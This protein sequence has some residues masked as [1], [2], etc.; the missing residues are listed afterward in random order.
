MSF[1]PPL[2]PKKKLS[3]SLDEIIAYERRR[4]GQALPPE[5]L[6]EA[7]INLQSTVAD[8]AAE[9]QALRQQNA[10]LCEQIDW[11]HSEIEGRCDALRDEVLDRVNDH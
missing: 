7:F 10:D 5:T 6:A 1:L 2:T 11:L 4:A 8:L 3:M 9:V